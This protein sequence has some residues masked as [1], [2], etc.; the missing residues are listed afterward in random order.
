M[1]I[2]NQQLDKLAAA[3]N[4]FIAHGMLLPEHSPPPG[5]DDKDDDGGPTD[6]DRVLA[7]VRLARTAGTLTNPKLIF[8]DQIF[9]LERKYP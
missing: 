9:F 1:L 7:D 3:R 5:F 8:I 6:G 4:N 2:T